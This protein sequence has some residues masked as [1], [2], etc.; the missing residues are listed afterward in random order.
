MTP[1]PALPSRWHACSTAMMSY[2]VPPLAVPIILTAA[3]AA[4]NYALN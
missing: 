4:I 1:G 3:L 2:F